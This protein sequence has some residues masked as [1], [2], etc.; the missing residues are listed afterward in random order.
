MRIF[1]IAASEPFLPRFARALLDGELIAEFRPRDAP[2]LL[3]AATLYLPTGR[4]CRSLRDA[5]V[6][7]TGGGGLILPRIVALGDIDEDEI[8]FAAGVEPGGSAILDLPPAMPPL[9]RRLVLASLVERWAQAQK[10]GEAPP[11]IVTGAQSAIGLADDLARLMDDMITRQAPWSRLDGLVPDDL[12]QQF[13]LTL[14]FLND[15]VRTWWPRVLEERGMIEPALRRDRLIAAEAARLTAQHSGPVIAAGSTGSMP[16]TAR[17]LAAIATLPQGALVLPGLDTVLDEESWR[18]I[19]ADAH[20]ENDAPDAAA[21][22][23]VASVS[24]PQFAMRALLARLGVSR[25]DVMALGGSAAHDRAALMSEALRPAPTTPAWSTRLRQPDIAAQIETAMN[26]VSVIDAANSREESLAIAVAM[27]EALH[28][29]R[30]AA[31]VT[32]DRML[33]RRVAS[34]LGRWAIDVPDSGG[35]PLIETAAGRFALIVAEAGLNDLEPATL[36][37]LVKHPLFRLGRTA[38]AWSEAIADLELAVL[39]G[40]RPA[41]GTAGLVA[42]LDAFCRDLERLKAGGLSTLHRADPRTQIATTQ[43]DAARALA[44]A[45]QGALA[46]LEDIVRQGVARNARHALSGLAMRHR[47]VLAHLT[48]E[49]EAPFASL[50]TRGGAMLIDALGAL[51]DEA[52]AGLVTLPPSDYGDTLA[53]ALA[54]RVIRAP[55]PPDAP[56]Q[57]L[58]PL[59]AR[60]GDVD[61]IILGGLVEGVWP[62]QTRT[63]AWLSRG[64]RHQI[65]L[66]APERRI[67]LSAHDFAQFMGAPEVILSHAAKTGGA[68]AVASR[69]LHRLQAVTPEACWQ[70]AQ[71][72]GRRLI[73]LAATLDWP[74]GA[75][76]RPVAQPMPK[77]ALKLRPKRLSVTEIETLIRDPYSIYARHVLCLVPLDPVDMPAGTAQR[78]SAI[79]EALGAFAR[80]HAEALPQDAAD[81]LVKLG[82]TAFAGLMA[83]PEARALWWPRFLR[84]ARWYAAWEKTRRAA[85]ERT[86]AEVG[87]RLALDID[88]AAFTLTGRADRIEQR[89][90]GA[91]AIVDFKT[92]NPPSAKEV[93]VGLSPQL[94]LE[95]AMLRGGGFSP[96]PAGVSVAELAYVR[97]SGGTPPGR[98]M[99]LVLRR[100]SGKAAPAM[101]PDEAADDAREKL[102][103]LIAFYA[104]ASNAYKPLALAKWRNRYGAYDHLARIAE[105]SAEGAGTGDEGGEP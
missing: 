86:H 96:I 44:I 4:A 67:G 40:P 90:D 32:P 51:V 46:P 42:A 16:A 41:A 37:A 94:T 55:G 88:G 74:A 28:Q 38:G 36:L 85:L 69:F 76:A 25:D 13:Q 23:D 59:E 33:A 98:P 11:P 24:H 70:A 82:E 20:G 103:A 12:A 89:R 63:D 102:V 14:S 64:M 53:A 105:W 68:P 81:E 80:A 2:H 54:D 77:P 79:H 57:I 30:R 48:A 45:L 50:G 91:Y 5:L 66:D 75:Q 61:R 22:A 3:S 1:T 58:G 62:P 19:E 99:P 34:A 7:E 47:E 97:L 65:G 26:G 72:R 56:L 83:Q 10:Q 17:F 52:G 43:M 35:E 21:V 6:A 49:D 92:G 71:A 60:L 100:G 84:I 101:S 87:G 15:I 93:A 78:G 31:L 29:G 9:A 95:A 18:A 39:R 73:D 8:D 27:R 104:D